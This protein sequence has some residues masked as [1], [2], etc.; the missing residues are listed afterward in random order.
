MCARGGRGNI[1]LSVNYLFFISVCLPWGKN[2]RFRPSVMWL[3]DNQIFP[4]LSFSNLLNELCE[5]MAS[6]ERAQVSTQWGLV[7]TDPPLSGSL[8]LFPLFPLKLFMAKQNHQS[9][10]LG[11]GVC[12]L[13]RL[14]CFELKAT[15]FFFCFYQHLPLRHWFSSVFW[16]W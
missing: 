12:L 13:P 14:L 15:F 7:T 2:Q 4:R 6:K 5:Q 16:V 1:W 3:K 10:S 11:T 9:W 8:W